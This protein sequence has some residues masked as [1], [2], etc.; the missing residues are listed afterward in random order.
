MIAKFQQAYAKA[1]S[2][3]GA[4]PAITQVRG[5]PFWKVFL[6]ARPRH[7]AARGRYRGRE[8]SVQVTVKVTDKGGGIGRLTWRVND[9]VK[10]TTLG[11]LNAKGEISRRFDLA[12]TDNVIEVTAENKR[13]FVRSLASKVTVKVDDKALKGV[14]DLYILALGVD[15]YREVKRRLQFAVADAKELSTALAAVG[16]DFYRREPKVVMLHDDEVA[17]ER[18]EK[19][20]AELG[21]KIKATDVFEL[22]MA[23]HGKT[24]GGDYYFVPRDIEQFTDEG[25][26]AKAFGPKQWVAWFAKIKAEKSI[27]IIDTCESGSAGKIFAG[28]GGSEYD[29]GYKRLMGAT[30]R[31]ILMSASEQQLAVEGY[32]GHGVFSYAFMEGLAH[33]DQDNAKQITLLGLMNYVDRRVPEISREMKACQVSGPDDYCQRPV[34]E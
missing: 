31:T 2:D 26:S 4:I 34:V 28:R 14:P 15:Q 27:W 11:G 22:F 13:G 17:A 24:V 25:I 33:A 16:K 8:T 6:H 29:A 9:Q 30:G 5:V 32:H 7:I 12:S 18:V 3:E 20:F 23:G 19:T 1:G 10:E 21:D